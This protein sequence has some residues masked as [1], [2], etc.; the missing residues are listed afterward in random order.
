[1]SSGHEKAC[2]EA[3]S[4]V[5]IIRKL[6]FCVFFPKELLIC[7]TRRAADQLGLCYV[8]LYIYLNKSI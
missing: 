8:A 3:H 5:N 2:S 7:E 1:M 6:A 4:S